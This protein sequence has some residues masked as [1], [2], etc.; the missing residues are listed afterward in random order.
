MKETLFDFYGEV[1]EQSSA[2]ATQ[3]TQFATLSH[4]LE[5][6]AEMIFQGIIWIPK[7]CYSRRKK[8]KSL[9][10]SLIIHEEKTKKISTVKEVGICESNNHKIL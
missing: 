3:V 4:V 6:T 1:S 2:F 10:K 9:L 8:V 7:K 5:G